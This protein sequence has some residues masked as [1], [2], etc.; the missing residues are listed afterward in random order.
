MMTDKTRQEIANALQVWETSVKEDKHYPNATDADRELYISLV[1]HAVNRLTEIGSIIRSTYPRRQTKNW[2]M[3]ACIHDDL[4]AEGQALSRTL[5]SAN[6]RDK[7][8]DRIERSFGV[9]FSS[10]GIH[11][12]ATDKRDGSVVYVMFYDPKYPKVTLGKEGEYLFV[13]TAD[14][15]ANYEILK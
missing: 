13:E 7:I 12:E 11:R 4:L 10:L 6:L 2:R 5:F 15:E 3:I 8:T 14:F 1:R 9:G